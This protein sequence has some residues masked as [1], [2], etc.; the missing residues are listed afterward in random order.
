MVSLQLLRI[1]SSRT[2]GQMWYAM[3][4]RGTF[5]QQKAAII[6]VSLVA[7]SPTLSPT[8]GLGPS[9]SILGYADDSD[10]EQDPN[11]VAPIQSAAPIVKEKA[12]DPYEALEDDDDDDDGGDSDSDSD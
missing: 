6:N 9:Q 10:E 5:L 3:A 7:T 1:L 2:V 12:K 4:S 8:P 11:D